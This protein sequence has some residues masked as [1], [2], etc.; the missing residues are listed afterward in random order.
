MKASRIFSM[1]NIDKAVELGFEVSHDN[2][3]YVLILY[4]KQIY[5]V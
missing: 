5:Y 2:I 3:P 1:Y 4:F